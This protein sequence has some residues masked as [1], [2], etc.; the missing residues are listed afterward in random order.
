MKQT[1][2]QSKKQSNKQTNK[3]TN[4]TTTPKAAAQ[5]GFATQLPRNAQTPQNRTTRSKAAFTWT[6]DLHL[7]SPRYSCRASSLMLALELA[8]S[9]YIL[10]S[11]YC[12][13]Q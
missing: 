8:L 6:M 13:W 10:F 3:Q 5:L 4:K 11:F 12:R 7:F 1:N 2:K 9:L